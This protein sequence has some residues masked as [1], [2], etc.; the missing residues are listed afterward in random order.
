MMALPNSSKM[1]WLEQLP[2]C[3]F[4]MT[5][6][7][8]STK[9]TIIFHPFI[10]GNPDGTDYSNCY[11]GWFTDYCNLGYDYTSIMHYS[12]TS[13]AINSAQNVMNP[14]D[15]S[16]TSTGN[17]VLSAL[18]IQKI[19]CLYFCDGTNHATCGGHKFGK[20]P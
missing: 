10:S 11:S 15:T 8:N 1:L 7:I 19:Q 20:L 12:L 17:S 18:D 5:R 6:V 3:Q 9:C 14:T 13:F 2:H 4:A 16:V